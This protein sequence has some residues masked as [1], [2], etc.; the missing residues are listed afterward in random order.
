MRCDIGHFGIYTAGETGNLEVID[1][2]KSNTI[3]HEEKRKDTFGS[4]V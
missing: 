2:G 4:D 1:G 3:Q